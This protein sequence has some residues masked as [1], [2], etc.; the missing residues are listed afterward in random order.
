MSKTDE[1]YDAEVFSR[2]S[3]KI[4]AD[5]ADSG[6][7]VAYAAMRVRPVLKDVVERLE[8]IRWVLGDDVVASTTGPSPQIA[9]VLRGIAELILERRIK[10]RREEWERDRR[11]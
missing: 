4:A 8:A 2:I 10:E 1:E 6:W 3:E 11:R 5:D 7:A 9:K